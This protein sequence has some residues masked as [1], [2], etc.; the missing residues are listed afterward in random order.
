MPHAPVIR[1]HSQ[2]RQRTPYYDIVMIC[3]K[4]DLL[5]T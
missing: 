4:I 2:N 3:Y 5:L 1:V